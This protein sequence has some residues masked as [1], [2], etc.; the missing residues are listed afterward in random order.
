MTATEVP[1]TESL[2]IEIAWY[3]VNNGPKTRADMLADIENL[4][5][6][7]NVWRSAMSYA[8]DKLPWVNPETG[9]VELGLP[10]THA[11]GPK[12]GGPYWDIDAADPFTVRY[13]ISRFR[14]SRTMAQRDVDAYQKMLHHRDRVDVKI[15]GFDRTLRTLLKVRLRSIEDLTEVIEDLEEELLYVEAREEA[16]R[17]GL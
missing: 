2:A 8:K 11:G 12:N 13:I 7:Y 16:V 1:T 14:Y 15:D 3:L 10:I 6:D 17:L 5:G 9:D 4:G